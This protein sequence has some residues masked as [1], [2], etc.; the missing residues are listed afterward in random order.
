MH[1]MVVW[2]ISLI[3]YLSFL[4]QV[5]EVKE[6]TAKKVRGSDDFYSN[7]ASSP[8]LTSYMAYGS[9]PN[10]VATAPAWTAVPLLTKDGKQL[11]LPPPVFVKD[12]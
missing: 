4:R 11:P 5:L 10:G 7:Y 6:E 3:S 2:W 12:R 8:Y 9:Y 1:A